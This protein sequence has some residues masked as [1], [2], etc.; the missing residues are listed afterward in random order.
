VTISHN[1][2]VFREALAQDRKQRKGRVRSKE[3]AFLPAAL[4]V[5]ERPVS[6]TGRITAWTLLLGLVATGAWLTLGHID[7]VASAQGK[8]I[9]TDAVKLVQAANIGVVRK[10]YVRDGTIVRKGEPLIDLD[11]TVST[12]EEAEA[13]K[14]L[15][16]AELD[17]A[18]D[19][20][21]ADALIGKGIH[22]APPTGTTPEVAETQLR[23]IKAQVAESGAA[24]AGMA[25]A[26]DSSLAEANS[27]AQQIR[28]YSDTV[29]VLDKEI[30]AMNGLAAKGYAP[31]LKLLEL[32]RQRRSEAGE[33]DVAVAQRARGQSD[34]RKFS[35]Q[36]TQSREQA[37]QTALADLAKAQS[38]AMVRQEELTKARQKSHLQR[39]VAPVDGIV[40]QLTVHTVGGVIEAVRPLMIIVP[41][42]ALTVEANV[43]NKDAGFVRQG[44]PVAVKLEAFPFT[45]Y[46]TVPGRIQSISSDAIDDKKLGPIYVARIKLLR[47]TIDRG[48]VVAPLGPGM[49]VTADIK[50]GRR[51]LLS[52]LL[53]PI[54]KARLEAGRER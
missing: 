17:V 13:S 36:L 19:S 10:I 22:F 1:W 37:R 42:G 7:I 48:D 51:S 32:Q 44:Q 49:T 24:T 40:Q 46:G 14:G 38:E 26:R 8:I 47:S 29:P 35:Q 54:D 52:Y 31:G 9:P 45:R 2:S 11:P 21:I 16:A 30:D 50:T 18:R 4:E 23:L 12:A 6:P 43:L 39:L 53:S 28:T 15:L 34:A 25:A 5:I 27:A 33:R 20:A 3:P 41:Y